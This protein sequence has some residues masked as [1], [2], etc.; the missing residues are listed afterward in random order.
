[1]P[2]AGAVTISVQGLDELR[3]DLKQAGNKVEQRKLRTKLK[4][5][6]EIVADDARGR[7]PVV[8]GDARSTLKAGATAGSA[9]VVGG[10]ADSP[11]YGWLDFGSRTPNQQVGPWRN[12]G[13][14]PHGGRFIYPAIKANSDELIKQVTDAVDEALTE[15]RL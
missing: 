8:S 6:A 7:V 9:F 11:Y 1:M 4:R 15:E 3:R 10:K 13:A 2:R 5:A 14:G 12:S